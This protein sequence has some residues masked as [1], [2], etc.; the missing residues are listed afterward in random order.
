MR[1]DTISASSSS[2]LTHSQLAKLAKLASS[3]SWLLA[4]IE[5][6]LA[7]IELAEQQRGS[8]GKH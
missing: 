8:S 7:E 1:V 6:E 5:L 4:K 3:V 2:I